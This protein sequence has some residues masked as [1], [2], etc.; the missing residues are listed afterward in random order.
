MIEGRSSK[1]PA[2]ST[3]IQEMAK[4]NTTA[5]TQIQKKKKINSPEQ[6]R[7]SLKGNLFP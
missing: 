2:L 7:K 1:K 3:V 4:L 5:S 6:Q